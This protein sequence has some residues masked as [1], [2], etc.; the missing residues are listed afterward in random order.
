[1]SV[2]VCRGFHWLSLCLRIQFLSGLMPSMTLSYYL[3]KVLSVC[4]YNDRT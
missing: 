2:G 4:L 3:E 1:M